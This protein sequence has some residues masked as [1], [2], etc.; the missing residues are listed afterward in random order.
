MQIVAQGAEATVY[1]SDG[2]IIKERISKSYRIP[3]LDLKITRSR[4]KKEAKIL[5]FLREKGIN[6]PTF[7]KTEGNK[8]YMEKVGGS[9]LKSIL[10]DSNY[11]S[12]MADVGKLIAQ[13]HSTNVVHGDLTTL[14]FLIGENLFMI[15]FGLSF[16]SY[17][18]EDKAVD[19]YVFERA[20]K[21][22]HKEEYLVPFYKSYLENGS[23]SVLKK[24]EAVR[25]RGR[26]REEE[27][28][29]M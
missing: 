18:D 3:Q 17:K 9:V 16:N 24:L 6:V 2:V 15:D 21:C 5:I 29:I 4:T 1:E 23:E 12:L 19:L 28:E 26:K 22:G 13:V 10:N 11:T 8:I 14:N 27:F 7:I 20:V 25:M